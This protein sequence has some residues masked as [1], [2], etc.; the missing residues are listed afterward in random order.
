MLAGRLNVISQTL[1]GRLSAGRWQLGCEQ[2]VELGQHGSAQPIHSLNKQAQHQFDGD[3]E[4]Q[5]GLTE[6]QHF[7]L[8]GIH[9]SVSS[10]G[11]AGS[12]AGAPASASAFFC[13]RGL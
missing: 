11:I 8:S 4:R 5:R 9:S 12:C 2:R 7:N 13:T 3:V 10:T 6:A 1:N